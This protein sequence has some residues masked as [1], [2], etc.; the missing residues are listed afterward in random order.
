[1]NKLLINI[2]CWF[3]PKKKNKRHFREKHGNVIKNNIINDSNKNN[4]N[5]ENILLEIKRDIKEIKIYQ[6]LQKIEND[7]CKTIDDAVK[8][9]IN[10]KDRIT[11]DKKF[12]PEKGLITVVIPIY[13]VAP[14]LERCLDSVLNQTYKNLQIICVND[15]SFDKSAE[16]IERYREKLNGQYIKVNEW[17]KNNN[18]KSIIKD[19]L[20]SNFL[21]IDF[22]ENQGVS[23]ARNVGIEL[24]KGEYIGF[25]D[26]DDYLDLNFYEKL[27][28]KGKENEGVNRIFSFVKSNEKGYDYFNKKHTTYCAWV[29]ACIYKTS[30]I[31]D[32]KMLFINEIITGGDE[33]FN[34]EFYINSQDA[35]FVDNV[36]FNHIVRNGSLFNGIITRELVFSRIIMCDYCCKYLNKIQIQD[37]MYSELYRRSL[38]NLFYYCTKKHHSTEHK[39]LLFKGIHNIYNKAKPQFKEKIA[40]SLECNFKNI[41]ED[42]MTFCMGVL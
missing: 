15:C 34:F 3:I 22:T 39:V 40:D 37:E 11:I 19:E 25:V 9:I 1:M 32:N 38:M 33:Q 31:I 36:Y 41:R 12:I 35:I 27:Y 21:F 17:D 30:F 23:V 8:R 42:F 28:E 10:Y 4:D 24:A 16:I 7:Y 20:R 5:K 2:C 18:H 13:N 26:S 29:W 14:Y 6:V